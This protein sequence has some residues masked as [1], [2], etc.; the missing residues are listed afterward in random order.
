[1]NSCLSRTGY[2][3]KESR[4]KG[5]SAIRVS[6]CEF[7]LWKPHEVQRFS[8][9]I[10]PLEYSSMPYVLQMRLHGIISSFTFVFSL[11]R[12]KKPSSSNWIFSIT[13]SACYN[14]LNDFQCLLQW[15]LWMG[16]AR[17]DP[18]RKTQGTRSVSTAVCVLGSGCSCGR[19]GRGWGDVLQSTMW[20]N[21][22]DKHPHL[23]KA[24]RQ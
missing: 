5:L 11:S 19:A 7:L 8:S 3:G 4:F 2:D 17:R 16:G 6:H 12:Q 24:K 22:K 10:C 13:S 9:S 1:M 15:H 21:R 14:V 18:K 20:S 23:N